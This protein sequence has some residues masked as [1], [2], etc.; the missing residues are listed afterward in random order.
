MVERRPSAAMY[1]PALVLLILVIADSIFASYQGVR[2]LTVPQSVLAFG[3]AL[4]F[5]LTAAIRY[6]RR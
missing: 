6:L 2:L 5:T 1:I 3:A 4:L